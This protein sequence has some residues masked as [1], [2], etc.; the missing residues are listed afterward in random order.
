M[1]AAI[2]AVL[3]GSWWL[4]ALRGVLGIAFRAM[5]FPQPGATML[6]CLQVRYDNRP[7][8]TLPSSA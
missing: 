8:S 3:V 5:A 7:T 6:S 4:M 1:K 2:A